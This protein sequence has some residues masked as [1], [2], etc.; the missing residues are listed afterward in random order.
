MFGSLRLWG[1]KAMSQIVS[2]Q[3][4]SLDVLSHIPTDTP[5]SHANHIATL[6]TSEN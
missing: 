4:F 2:K 3:R 1:T 5:V 6:L